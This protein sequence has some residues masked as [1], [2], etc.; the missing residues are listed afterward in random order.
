[1]NKLIKTAAAVGI[2]SA[3]FLQPAFAAIISF[4]GTLTSAA[5]NNPLD[6]SSATGQVL[7]TLN[8]VLNTMEVNIVYSGL[9]SNASGA[10]IHCCLASP[11][12]G[13]NVGV[14]T[15]T[16]AFP[17]FAIGMGT[18]SG[19]YDAVIDMTLAT[20][21]NQAVGAFLANNGNNPLTAEATLFAA[22][23]N[24]ETYLNIHSANFPG[25]EIR[26][27]LVPVPEPVTMSVFGAGLA[28]VALT[29][30]RRKTQA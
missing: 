8:D 17:G 10:H 26:T 21:Y 28:G 27:F 16:P 1:M 6:T 9:T 4:K 20:S 29:R 11:F 24:G 14:A 15:T 7:V 22:I 25:G 23:E 13:G 30:R 5:E 18:T 19:S 2:V 3:T 12:A